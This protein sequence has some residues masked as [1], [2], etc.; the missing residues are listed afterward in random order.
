DDRLGPE[1]LLRAELAEQCAYRLSGEDR[2]AE[3][4]DAL[5]R[6]TELYERLAMPWQALSTRTRALA[7]ATASHAPAARTEEAGDSTGPRTGTADTAETGED[8]TGEHTAADATGDGDTATDA[9]DTD[10][11]TDTDTDD[12]TVAA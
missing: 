9:A 5:D 11:D 10:T 3:S 4:M 6:A 12:V 1:D 8:P 2:T 7:W